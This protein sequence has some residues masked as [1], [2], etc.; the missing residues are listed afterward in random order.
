MWTY[1]ASQ[2]ALLQ[3]QLQAIR[4]AGWSGI[5]CERLSS[6]TVGYIVKYLPYYS[7]GTID[8]PNYVDANAVPGSYW[9]LHPVPEPPGRFN[10]IKGQHYAS[11]VE[12]YWK[13]STYPMIPNG[14]EADI[15]NYFNTEHTWVPGHRGMIIGTCSEYLH[16]NNPGTAIFDYS[17]DP[18]AILMS[19]KALYN[20]G[21]DIQN[22]TFFFWSS[23]LS[24]FDDGYGGGINSGQSTHGTW[25]MV[26]SLQG[27]PYY[28]PGTGHSFPTPIWS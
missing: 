21:F 9:A 3:T 19:L 2:L 23:T 25:D 8:M 24:V 1:S 17:E 22:F 15:I 18:N 16:S 27:L 12:A 7:Y 13:T 26:K 4:D 11:Y 20:A 14:S 10:H 28:P 6:V 5:A